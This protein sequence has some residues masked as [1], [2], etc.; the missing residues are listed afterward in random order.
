MQMCRK[1]VDHAVPRGQMKGWSK[2]R[3]QCGTAPIVT[4]VVTMRDAPYHDQ[5]KDRQNERAVRTVN[6]GSVLSPAAP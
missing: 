3:Y 6:D 5:E 2:R 1:L 4:M